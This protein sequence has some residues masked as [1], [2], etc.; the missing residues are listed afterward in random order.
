[1]V[2]PAGPNNGRFSMTPQQF[3][4]GDRDSHPHWVDSSYEGESYDSPEDALKEGP[5]AVPMPRLAALIKAIGG[6]DEVPIRDLS[7]LFTHDELQVRD[8]LSGKEILSIYRYDDGGEVWFDEWHPHWD[9]LSA[10][11]VPPPDL[12]G[13]WMLKIAIGDD[14]YTN[15]SEL[16]ELVMAALDVRAGD[17]LRQLRRHTAGIAKVTERLDYLAS[18]AKDEAALS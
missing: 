11:V 12:K 18:L 2:G 17:I 9:A 3:L 14:A 16:A 1:M 5:V 6:L 13:D 10:C 15:S 4:D 8:C 7:D